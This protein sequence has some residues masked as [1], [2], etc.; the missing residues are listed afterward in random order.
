MASKKLA[1]RAA[2]KALLEEKIRKREELLRE[3]GTDLEKDPILKSLR[4]DLRAINRRI[5]AI[6]DIKATYEKVQR[7]REER[8]AQQKEKAKKKEQ[9]EQE[10]ET[11]KRQQKKQT[12]KEERVKKAIEKKQMTGQA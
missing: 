10:Q 4:A 5:K 9:M 2:Q 7:A 6:E 1:T 11:S 12:K 3:R 8:I